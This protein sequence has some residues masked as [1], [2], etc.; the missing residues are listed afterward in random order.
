MRFVV[1]GIVCPVNEAGPMQ[2]PA[3]TAGEFRT[4][5]THC[6]EFANGQPK[7]AP[8]EK[9]VVYRLQHHNPNSE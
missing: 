3:T 5:A 6:G 4:H 8:V 2:T 7:V 9:A 1:V